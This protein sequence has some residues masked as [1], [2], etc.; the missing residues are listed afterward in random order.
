M[1]FLQLARRTGRYLADNVIAFLALLVALSGAAYAADTVGS[2]DIIDNS[3][4]SADIHANT[5]TR[6]DM[7]WAK[8]QVVAPPSGSGNC[9]SKTGEL[10]EVFDAGWNDF[11]AWQNVS[12]G[13]QPARFR[14]NASSEVA[15]QGL[16]RTN[17]PLL[18]INADILR[19]P[20][21][22]RP[23]GTLVFPVA[24]GLAGGGDGVGVIEVRADG[25]V[26]FRDASTQCATTAF[27]SLG[28]VTF[29]IG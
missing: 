26:Y 2:P 1:G 25:I 28:G 9:A 23:M 13:Y 22:Y 7:A 18:G 10:C 5:I 14:R 27:V 6:Q 19:L 8:W 29:P 16:V 4:L 12:G 15:L 24:C 3:I 11:V 17:H 20:T 21:G